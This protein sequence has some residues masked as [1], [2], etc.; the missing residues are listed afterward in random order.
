M[1][2]TDEELDERRQYLADL[3]EQIAAQEADNAGTLQEKER[4][5]EG[6][7]LDAEAAELEQQLEAVKAAGK[8]G[9]IDTTVEAHMTSQEK[10]IEDAKQRDEERIALEEAQVA[11]LKAAAEGPNTGVPGTSGEFGIAE[12]ER[13]RRAAEEAKAEKEAKKKDSSN[14]GS[15]NSGSGNSGSGDSGNGNGGNA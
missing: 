8:K 13:E 12:E 14:S 1:A 6:I 15:G 9:R 5:M 7:R 3:R 11:A 10:R 2:P 4:E